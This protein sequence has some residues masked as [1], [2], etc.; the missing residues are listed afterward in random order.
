MEIISV[1]VDEV[2]ESC[3]DCPRFDFDFKGFLGFKKE[4]P[5]CLITGADILTNYKAERPGLCPLEK[6]GG[7]IIGDPE[8]AK[9]IQNR[10]GW[11]TR[12]FVDKDGVVTKEICYTRNGKPLE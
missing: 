3:W 6:K 8:V 9:M 11:F 7:W 1:F 2:P 12:R 10:E 4:R 5:Y